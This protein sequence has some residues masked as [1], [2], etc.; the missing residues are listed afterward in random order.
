MKEDKTAI[1]GDDK[2]TSKT[3][4]SKTHERRGSKDKKVSE[5]LLEISPGYFSELM[6]S[7]IEKIAVPSLV[8][9]LVFSP[10]FCIIKGL[11]KVG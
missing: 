3:D 6:K 8:N 7:K 10:A 4:R 9:T 5:T 11:L 2:D 1:K